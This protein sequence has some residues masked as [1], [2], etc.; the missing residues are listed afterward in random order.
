MRILCGVVLYRKSSSLPGKGGRTG[1]DGE[2]EEDG[3]G[4]V[5]V[6][7]CAWLRGYHKLY[8]TS[9]SW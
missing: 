8:G 5:V 4:K 3:R 9:V 2:E 7:S 6:A 1:G